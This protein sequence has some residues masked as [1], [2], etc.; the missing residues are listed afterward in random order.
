MVGNH[1]TIDDPPSVLGRPLTNGIN[2]N[3]NKMTGLPNGA[4]VVNGNRN[5]E[6]SQKL[7]IFSSQDEKGTTRQAAQFS[8][9]AAEHSKNFDL[10]DLTFTLNHKRSSLPWKSFA[11]LNAIEDIKNLSTSISSAQRSKSNPALGFI[12][13][14]QGGQWAQMGKELVCYPVFDQRLEEAESYL[15]ELGCPWKLR[16]EMFKP[17]SESQIN[18]P[19]LSQPLHCS[20]DCPGRSSQ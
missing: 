19:S 11:I 4:P 14:G 13:T 9:F 1:I 6:G 10:E 8:N 2:G 15:L 12:F 20:P 7:V 17:Q 5:D 16:E 3:Y 18:K